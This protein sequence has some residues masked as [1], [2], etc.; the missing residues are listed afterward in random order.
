MD[1]DF[2]IKLPS[3]NSF[4]FAVSEDDTIGDLRTK[5]YEKSGINVDDVIFL[6]DDKEVSN[7]ADKIFKDRLAKNVRYSEMTTFIKIKE[8]KNK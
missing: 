4:G 7:N 5:I 3:G 1:Y 2:I 8:E 6:I